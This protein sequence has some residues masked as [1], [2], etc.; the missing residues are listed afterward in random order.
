MK[1]F[2]IRTATRGDEE[3][4]WEIFRAVVA[5]GDA[6]VFEGGMSRQEAMD[7]WFGSGVHVYVA[8]REGKV[9]G[10]YVLKAIKPG[11]GA[12]IANGAYMVLPAARGM[13]IGRL[14][15]EHSLKEAKRL[16]FRAMQF[17]MVVSTNESAVRLWKGLGFKVI[18]TLPG[19]FRHSTLGFVDAYVMWHTLKGI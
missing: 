8:E 4:I 9:V 10:S 12:H 17:N 14:M 18:G 16:G 15:G 3:K 5:G 7:W 1:H 6:F 19:A 2:N 13:G 11:R